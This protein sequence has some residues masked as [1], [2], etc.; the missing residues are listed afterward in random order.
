MSEIVAEAF[1]SPLSAF[2]TALRFLA[3]IAALIAAGGMAFA[4][5]VH[6]RRP[7]EA[8]V[9]MRTIVVSAVVAA[10]ATAVGVVVQGAL[11]TGRGV[12]A[13]ADIPVL[14]AVLGSPFGTS[15]VVRLFSLA[16][17]VLAAVAMWRSWA[18]ALGLGAAVVVPGSFLLTGHTVQAEPTWLA[19]A[20][21]LTHTVAAAVWFG[22]LVLL[23]VTFRTRRGDDDSTATAA[24]VSRFSGMAT[25]AVILV[26][27]AGAARVRTL[28]PVTASALGSGYGLVLVAKVLLVG[29]VLLV[30]GYNHRYLVPAVSSAGDGAQRR[31][32]TTA[33]LEALALLTVIAISAVLVNLDPPDAVSQATPAIEEPAPEERQL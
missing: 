28:M 24:L 1:A 29:A 26:T 14:T 13:A 18:I 32:K 22:G 20:S 19:I 4:T 25:I 10:G 12:A 7:S 23:T 27:V 33:R 30:A 11:I 3:Y 31:L 8:R 16:A 2:A 15:A 21:A 17:L 6:D 5:I 9:L